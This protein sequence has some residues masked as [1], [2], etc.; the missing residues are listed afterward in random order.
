LEDYAI[1]LWANNSE[2]KASMQAKYNFIKLEKVI[3]RDFSL[4]KKNGKVHEVNEDINDGVYC[5]A[6]A[7]GLGKTTFL[8]S[9]NYGLT[10]IV[11]DSDKEVF[12]PG[13][14]LTANKKHT[15]RYFSGR[16]SRVSQHQKLANCFT[17][18]I[19]LLC[20]ML[21]VHLFLE[22]KGMAA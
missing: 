14:I 4:Y 21:L 16:I 5:L 3:F 10:G 7:N 2:N 6:G 1:I 8:N 9:I 17:F 15:D 20:L 11:L 22:M 19:K 18:K 13:E 12:S